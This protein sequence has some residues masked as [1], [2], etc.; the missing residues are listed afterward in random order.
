M[1]GL[2]IGTYHLRHPQLI[3]II[4]AVV[5]FVIAIITAWFFL[6]KIPLNRTSISQVCFQRFLEASRPQLQTYCQTIKKS[7]CHLDQFTEDE[8]EGLIL[9]FEAEWDRCQTSIK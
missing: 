9:T 3:G 8:W 1:R 4:I 7:E 6:S 2:R 5:F